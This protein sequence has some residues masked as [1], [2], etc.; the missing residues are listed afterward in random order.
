MNAISPRNV[1]ART[2]H[3]IQHARRVRKHHAASVICESLEDRTLLS[4]NWSLVGPGL[5]NVFSQVQTSVNNQLLAPSAVSYSLPLVGTQLGQPGDPVGQVFEN[6]SQAISTEFQQNPPQPGQ[7]PATTV[8][9]DL[10]S[11]LAAYQPNVSNTGLSGSQATFN[12]RASTSTPLTEPTPLAL[13]LGLPG[14]SLFGNFGPTAPQAVNV[15]LTFSIDVYFGVNSTG[16]FVDPTQNTATSPLLTVGIKATLGTF[17]DTSASLNGVSASVTGSSQNSSS[18]EVPVTFNSSSQSVIYGFAASNLDQVNFDASAMG[19]INLAYALQVS[20]APAL[21]L[22][23]GIQWPLDSVNSNVSTFAALSDGDAPTVS[24]SAGLDLSTLDSELNPTTSPIIQQLDQKVAPL[25]EVIDL[26]YQNLPVLSN[27][28]I[29]VTLRNLLPDVLPQSAQGLLPALDTLHDFLDGIGSISLPQGSVVSFASSTLASGVDTRATIASSTLV[30]DVEDQ[31]QQIASNVNSIVDPFLSALDSAL[32]GTVS[33]PIVADPALAFDALLTSDNVALFQYQLQPVN[34]KNPI[35]FSGNLGPELGPLAPPI[36]IFLQLSAAFGIDSA[37]LTLGYDTYGFN[38]PDDNPLDGLF[39]ADASAV[40][41]GSIGIKGQLDLELGQAGVEGT[42][43]LGFGVTGINT[44]APYVSSVETVDSKDNPKSEPVLQLNDFTSDVLEGGPFC[45]FAVGGVANLSLSVFVTLGISPFDV[46]YSYPLGSLTLFDFSCPSCQPGTPPQLAQLFSDLNNVQGV[47][48]VNVGDIT[49]ELPN[50]TQILVLDMGENASNRENVNDTGATDENFEIALPPQS[51]GQGNSKQALVVSAFG[52]SETIDGADTPGTTIVV[53]AGAN[54]K[55]ETVT[56]DPDVVANAYMI[57][58]G[59]GNDFQY[60]GNG[61]SYM[62][63]GTWNTGHGDPAQLSTP[64]ITMNTLQGGFGQNTLVGGNLSSAGYNSEKQA[65]WNILCANPAEI[66]GAGQ[67]GGA[68]DVLDAGNAGATMKGGGFGN[69]TFAGSDDPLAESDPTSV[70]PALACQYVMIAGKDDQ[71]LGGDSMQEGNG[72]TDFQWQEGAGPLVVR[73]LSGTDNECQLDVLG[74]QAAETWTITALEA[75]VPGYEVDGTFDGQSIGQID[76][77]EVPDVNVDADDQNNTG[78]E[79]YVVNDL[80]VADVTQVN[81][82]LHEYQTTPD[83][84]GDHVTIN[85]PAGNDTVVMGSQ[86][87]FTGQYGSN[88]LPIYQTQ[89]TETTITASDP[90]AAITYSIDAALPKSS[91][92]LNVNTFAGADS[93]TIT[94]TQPCATTVS[95]GGGNDTITVGGLGLALDDIQGSLLID[96]GAGSNQIMF[97]DS[98]STIGDVLTLTSSLVPGYSGAGSTPQASLIR[99]TGQVIPSN[100]NH[101]GPVYRY[102]MT[103]KF[104]ATGGNYSTGVSLIGTS[105]NDPTHPDQI[106]VQSVLPGAP[107]SVQTNGVDDQVYVGFDGGADGATSDPSSTLDYLAST[108]GVFDAGGQSTALSIDDEGSPRFD[109]YSVTATDVKRVNNPAT[110]KYQSLA[111]L[112]LMTA[113]PANNTIT[114]M[115]TATATTTIVDT[116][117]G[118]NAISVG[119]SSQTLNKVLGNLTINGGAG[120][121]SL[122]IDDS[123]AG[124]SQT[125]DLSA[126]QFDREGPPD[127]MVNYSAISSLNFDAG[128]NGDT[129]TIKVTGTPGGVPVSVQTGEGT[130]NL[131]VSD[132]DDIQG[133]LTFDWSQGFDS[134]LISDPV[135]A[136]TATYQVLPDKITRTGSATIQFDDNGDPLTSMLISAGG[137]YAAQVDVPNTINPTP[138]TLILGSAGDTVL[139]SHDQ[140]D[141]DTIKG[142]LTINGTS[143]TVV[144]LFD[145]NGPQGRSYTLDTGSLH[146]NGSLPAIAFKSLGKLDLEAASNSY[147]TAQGTAA[148]TSVVLDL[149]QGTNYVEV[150]SVQEQLASIAGPLTVNGQSG[151]DT[152]TL[153]DSGTSSLV[154]YNFDINSVAWSTSSSSGFVQYSDLKTVALSGTDD[155]GT[156]DLQDVNPKTQLSVSAS[157]VNNTLQGDYKLIG[158]VNEVWSIVADDVASLFGSATFYN[159]ANLVGGPATDVFAFEP[160]AMLTGKITGGGGSDWLDYSAYNHPV[161]VNLAKH[162]ATAVMG[163]IAGIENVRGSASGNTLTG[164]S[165]GNILI[166]GAG[167]DAIRGG[168]GASILIGDAGTDSVT[169]GRGGTILIGGTTSYDSGSLANDLALESLLTEWQ[170]KRPYKARIKQI[171]TGANSLVWKVTVHDDGSANKL[172][173]GAGQD[174]FFKGAKD[175]L[176]NRKPGERVN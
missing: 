82:N 129:N 159:V 101:S 81:L 113:T 128:D 67:D 79:S 173:G 20:D 169:A 6:L 7:M 167:S 75:G 132:L 10:N 63:G 8:V 34:A 27:L 18:L 90:A 32:D 96:A 48:G 148:G 152:L 142:A 21:S 146:F 127:N 52:A 25:K 49:T 100:P 86:Q 166:G 104:Q 144:R 153:V 94:A 33:I 30:T 4:L 47:N 91:D 50:T 124:S 126:T 114:V 145:Q 172:K 64:I 111:Q 140:Q 9:S 171:M 23:L 84:E 161:S 13:E 3:A 119:D 149:G 116:G 88:G 61:N 76:A 103:I 1:V 174:W 80:S 5:Q 147:V 135:A 78:G 60:L 138:L 83:A 139:V 2:H 92:S 14:L 95:T 72:V 66:L 133:P 41:E 37:G 29:D 56:V 53:V 69:D 175:K 74:T 158:P 93:V 106:Y 70:D 168:A 176:I 156:Y 51:Q 130:A 154:T 99:Y 102:P 110:I 97:D 39:I 36:P 136:E 73:G 109:T 105:S 162:T 46:S 89:W 35:L 55:P 122:T 107:T 59:D 12:V 112:L 155:S 150:G 115:G 98:A 165:Q 170:P 85:G 134:L 26:F 163:G 15:Q 108:L 11:A 117:A 57:G 71:N 160:D 125:Y 151:L 68:N 40:L 120:Q 65:S 31:A 16:F 43:G 157:G 141:L 28:G 58:G 17:E 22:D 45:P 19:S 42:L 118:N 123:G 54:A 44:S 137:L 121:D 24:V 77:Y 143:S 131:S 62:V 87:F 164:D 38:N